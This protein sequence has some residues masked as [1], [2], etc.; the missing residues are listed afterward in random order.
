M[1]DKIENMTAWN[2]AVLKWKEGYNMAYVLT[3]GS[4]YIKMTDTGAVTKTDNIK[5]ARVYLTTEKAKERMRK[6][7]RKTKG[8]YI[9]D[10][11]THS[12]YYVAK[13]RIKFPKEVREMLYHNADGRCVL[14]GRKILYDDVSLDHV[15]PLAMG[16]AD[17]ISN[18]Q[19]TC[20]AC[21]LFKGSVLPSDFV[22]RVTE[23]FLYQM[24]KKQGSNFMWKIVHRLLLKML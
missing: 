6:A 13:G 15:I 23:I 1:K 10:I 19:I 2:I 4:H 9:L 5:E 17:D 16:G 20:R 14:C 8:Y 22:D 7:P 3:N 21:N 12:K 11:G 24:E 18:V